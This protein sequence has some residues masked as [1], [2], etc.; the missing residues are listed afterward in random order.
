[1]LATNLFPLI[2]TTTESPHLPKQSKRKDVAACDG[3]NA[4]QNLFN[5]PFQLPKSLL[6]LQ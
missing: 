2:P 1:M 5:F 3:C 6:P 4:S